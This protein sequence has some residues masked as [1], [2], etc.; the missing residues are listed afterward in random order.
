[1]ACKTT[2]QHNYLYEREHGSV[3]EEVEGKEQ[4]H[5]GSNKRV[6]VCVPKLIQGGC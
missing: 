3:N 2:R 4:G 1:M 6:G 5:T